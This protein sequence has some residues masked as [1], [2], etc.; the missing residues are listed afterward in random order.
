M[1]TA[2]DKIGF[3]IREGRRYEDGGMAWYVRLQGQGETGLY[4]SAIQKPDLLLCEEETI[5]RCDKADGKFDMRTDVYSIGEVK[6]RN[7]KDNEKVSYLELAGKVNFLLEA[8]DGR[9]AAPGIQLLGWEI[10]LTLFNQGGSVSTHPLNINQ[11]P[12]EFLRILLGITFADGI[13]LSFNHTISPV[14]DDQKQIQISLPDQDYIVFIDMLLFSSGSLH[15]RGTTVWCSK[16]TICKQPEEEVVLKDSWVDPL[17]QFS[18]GR[19]LKMLGE[20]GVKGIPVLVHEQQVQMQHPITGQFLNQSTHI[21]RSLVT[22]DSRALYYLHVLSCLVS[23][24]RGH[25]LFNFTCLA[26][27]L[28]GIIDCLCGGSSLAVSSIWHGILTSSS[29]PQCS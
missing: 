18:E 29:P 2:A 16:V 14:K 7:S 1:D 3:A 15:G 9:Y 5:M 12:E 21:L 20:A 22:V 8:Q 10:I 27:L 11:F 28:V 13:I 4:T 25:P 19:I 6:K 26:E 24:P 17:R 23:K